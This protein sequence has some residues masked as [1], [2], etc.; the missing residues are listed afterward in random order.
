MV[1]LGKFKFETG[2]LSDDLGFM[3]KCL[4]IS[5]PQKAVL[6]LQGSLQL[7]LELS[8]MIGRIREREGVTPLE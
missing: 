5:V 7:R 1:L 8:V 3:I 6:D 4:A 2:R